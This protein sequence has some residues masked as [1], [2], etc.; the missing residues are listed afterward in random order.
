[1]GELNHPDAERDLPEPWRHLEGRVQNVSELVSN[2]ALSIFLFAELLS[3]VR[4]DKLATALNGS[5]AP[6]TASHRQATSA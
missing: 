3:G 4:D 1:M 2:F 6:C 5:D